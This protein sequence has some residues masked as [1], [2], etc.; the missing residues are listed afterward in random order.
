MA[1]ETQKN[2]RPLINL[3][4]LKEIF[5]PLQ[6]P[7]TTALPLACPNG[8]YVVAVLISISIVL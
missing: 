6:S 1:Y 2:L 3:S 8:Q 5:A 4:A 7:A